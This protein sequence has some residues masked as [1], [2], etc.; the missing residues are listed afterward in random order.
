MGHDC[1]PVYLVC[2][3]LWPVPVPVPVFVCAS[4]L[5]HTAPRPTYHVDGD[6][7]AVRAHQTRRQQSNT[8]HT[9]ACRNK[10]TGEK[11]AVR[12]KDTHDIIII[13]PHHHLIVTLENVTMP[14]LP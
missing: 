13:I 6:G 9:L 5:T 7:V 8:Q 12:K 1:V 14:L 4:G 10:E 3:C 2:L 11:E